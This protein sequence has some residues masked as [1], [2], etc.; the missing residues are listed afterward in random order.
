V[1]ATARST[2]DCSRTVLIWF[3]SLYLGWETFKWLQLLGFGV[4]VYG[5]LCVLRGRSKHS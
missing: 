5:T 4:L 2:I 1:S 3:V